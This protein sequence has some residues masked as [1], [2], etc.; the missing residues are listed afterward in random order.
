MCEFINLFNINL[1]YK[2]DGVNKLQFLCT[3]CCFET[4]MGIDK[5][6]LDDY[7]K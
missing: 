6:Y 1:K 3:G 7:I 2:I 5:G 4:I